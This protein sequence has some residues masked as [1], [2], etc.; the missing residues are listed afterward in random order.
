ML[1][2]FAVSRQLTDLIH[3]A[4]E[5]AVKG[6]ELA[7]EGHVHRLAGSMYL[8]DGSAGATYCVDVADGSCNCP[9]GHAPHVGRIKFCKH[10]CAVMLAKGV[11]S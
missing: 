2:R 4:Q 7:V 1:T 11:Q 5:R 8:V 10:V 6:A 9:D 3:I